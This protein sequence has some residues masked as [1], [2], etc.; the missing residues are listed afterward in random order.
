MPP[1]KITD[2]YGHGQMMGM[3][4]AIQMY[5]NADEI[6]HRVPQTVVD[7]I[8]RIAANDLAGYLKKPEEDVML[9]V[10]QRLKDIK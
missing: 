8:K 7:K 3:L 4:V 2:E 6:G 10:E 1:I 5:E 9:L